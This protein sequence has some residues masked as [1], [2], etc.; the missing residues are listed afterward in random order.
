MLDFKK[1]SDKGDSPLMLAIFKKMHKAIDLL[2]PKCKVN[3]CDFRRNTPF[4]VAAANGDT[5]T[6]KLLKKHGECNAS[7]KNIDGQTALHRA[8]Y[9]G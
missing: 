8:C 1:R 9:F 4:I 7:I 3:V 6:L 5:E 2:I